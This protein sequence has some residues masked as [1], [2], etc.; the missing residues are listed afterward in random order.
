MKIKFREKVNLDTLVL[1]ISNSKTRLKNKLTTFNYNE[2]YL[3]AQTPS[4]YRF[5]FISV[6]TL[7]LVEQI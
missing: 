1:R 4:I 7:L 3:L 2:T 5:N 6:I